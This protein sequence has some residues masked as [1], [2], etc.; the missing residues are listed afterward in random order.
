MRKKGDN[1]TDDWERLVFLRAQLDS[2]YEEKLQVVEK[3][4]NMTQN[5]LKE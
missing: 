3:M 4:H 5:F 2:M 1:D